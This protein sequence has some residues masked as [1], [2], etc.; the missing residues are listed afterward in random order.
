VCTFE[1]RVRI[2]CVVIENDCLQ[3]AELKPVYAVNNLEFGV[4]RDARASRDKY[5]YFGSFRTH[6][7]Y[8]FGSFDRDAPI[9]ANVKYTPPCSGCSKCY[10]NRSDLTKRREEVKNKRWWHPFVPTFRRNLG[11]L[12]ELT[13]LLSLVCRTKMK[14]F[15]IRSL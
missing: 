3:E 14:N 4:F 2:R 8:V 10:L 7:P 15:I 11:E 13:F 6:A 5:W 1:Q 9:K 12:N